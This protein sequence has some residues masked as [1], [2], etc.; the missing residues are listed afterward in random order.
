M[1]ALLA[2][3]ACTDAHLYGKNYT[4]NQADRISFEGNLCTD[5]PGAIAFPHLTPPP[6]RGSHLAST[7]GRTSHA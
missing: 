5:D 7:K 2:A 6:N 3:S 1:F 4:P